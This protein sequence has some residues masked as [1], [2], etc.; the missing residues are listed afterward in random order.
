M[1]NLTRIFP[2]LVSSIEEGLLNCPGLVTLDG[3]LKGRNTHTQS[4]KNLLLLI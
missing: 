3:H 2:P 4:K 1:I